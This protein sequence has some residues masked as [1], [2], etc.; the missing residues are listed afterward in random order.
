MIQ[1]KD[2]QSVGSLW[3]FSVQIP[4]AKCRG[5]KLPRDRNT[6]QHHTCLSSTSLSLFDF[7]VQRESWDGHRTRNRWFHIS[8]A[9]SS[10]CSWFTAACSLPAVLGK[11][12]F[13][14]HR[15]QSSC[16]VP[17]YLTSGILLIPFVC[18]GGL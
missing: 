13:Q 4:R 14:L 6:S 11:A 8:T 16:A 10:L 1:S 12:S 7:G 2:P 3:T 18:P 15:A 9:V 5:V 17:R